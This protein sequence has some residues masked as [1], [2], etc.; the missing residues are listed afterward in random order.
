MRIWTFATV[1]GGTLRSSADVATGRY[2]NGLLIMACMA[3]TNLTAILL[4]SPVVHTIAS[5]YY[6]SVNSA[7]ALVFDPLRY[8][9]MRRQPPP[10]AWV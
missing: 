2:H 5:D 3:I 6:A 8:P 4:L 9:D 1:I 7:C 10:D